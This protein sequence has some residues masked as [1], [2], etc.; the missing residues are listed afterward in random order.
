MAWQ[1]LMGRSPTVA[2]KPGG[3]LVWNDSANCALHAPRAV[4]LFYDSEENRLGIR[5][6]EVVGTPSCAVVRSTEEE[7]ERMAFSVEAWRHLQGVVDVEDLYVTDLQAPAPPV[8]PGDLGDEGIWW[9]AL[10]VEE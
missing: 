5:K 3:R 9:F 7:G 6:A 8:P 1:K 2:L 10:P 4:E